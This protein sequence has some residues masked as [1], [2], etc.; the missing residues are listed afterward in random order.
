MSRGFSPGKEQEL[1]WT[2]LQKQTNKL[3]DKVQLQTKKQ[4]NKQTRGQD[5]IANRENQGD[6]ATS[7]V[8]LP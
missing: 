2:R 8:N 1:Q 4:T 5:S 3:E 7:K 6:K